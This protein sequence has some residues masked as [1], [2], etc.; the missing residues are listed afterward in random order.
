MDEVPKTAITMG[1]GGIM[2][3][4]KILVIANGEGKADVVVNINEWKNNYR[5]TSNYVQMHRDVILIV[6]EAA[7]QN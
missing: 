6:D 5:N 4:K 3:A 1:L 7:A 2:Q